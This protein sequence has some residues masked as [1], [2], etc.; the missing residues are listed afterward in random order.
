MPIKGA[1]NTVSK[2][3]TPPN[4]NAAPEA[5]AACIGL[6]LLISLIPNSSLICAP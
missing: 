1:N 5:I 6:A 3:K 2:G 4:V